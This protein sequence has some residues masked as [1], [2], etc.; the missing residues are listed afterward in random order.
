VFS[1]LYDDTGTRVVIPPASLPPAATLEAWGEL[2]RPVRFLGDGAVRYGDLIRARLGP[3]TPVIA[4]PPVA[5]TIGRL[6]ARTPDR[7][8]LPHAVVPIYIRKP[9]AELA[10]DRQGRS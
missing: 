10:R 6:A 4:P 8:I 2:E 1:A 3:E 7:G 9:D 5:A